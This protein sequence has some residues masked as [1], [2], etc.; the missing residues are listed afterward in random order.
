M[1]LL[2]SLSLLLCF[3]CSQVQE[4]NPQRICHYD[5]AFEE[6]A[7]DARSG[8]RMR[9]ESVAEVC[10]E[11][12]K[13]EVRKGYRDGYTTAK[14]SRPTSV[15]VK[16]SPESKRSQRDNYTR[17]CIENFGKKVCGFGCIESYG[18]AKCA[19]HPGNHC[20]DEFGKIV[21]GHDCREEQGKVVCEYRE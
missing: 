12:V 10:S 1:K 6:G 9:G 17:M 13:A 11:T 18:K 7:E 20:L 15:V 19:R 4:K 16:N 8:E 2:T 21:C 3:S 14:A 5:G